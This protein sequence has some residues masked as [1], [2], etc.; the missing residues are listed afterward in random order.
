MVYLYI[1][2]SLLFILYTTPLSIVISS[3]AASHHFY[4]D[5]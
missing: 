1:V 4:A 3:Y 2:G 5:N